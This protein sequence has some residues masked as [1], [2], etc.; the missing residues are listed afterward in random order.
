[1]T[2]GYIYKISCNQTGECYIGSTF[3]PEQRKRHH[4]MPSNPC[5]SKQIIER[6]D[7]S[8]DIIEE[9]DVATNFELICKESEYIKNTANCINTRKNAFMT[10]KEKSQY[11]MKYRRENPHYK[12]ASKLAIK[13]FFERNPEKA[14]EYRKHHYAL[15]KQKQIQ[16]QIDQ[17]ID[18]GA[19]I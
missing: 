17:Y 12:E 2:V 18:C 6:G 10:P 11:I 13:R 3:N 16:Q 15:R 1:M 8:F 14:K 4:R 19:G 7:Y 5:S 9:L